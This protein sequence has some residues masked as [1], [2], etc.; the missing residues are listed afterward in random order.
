MVDLYIGSRSNSVMIVCGKSLEAK[1]VIW[2]T[3]LNA[4]NSLSS[5]MTEK[6]PK[7]QNSYLY[8]KYSILMSL[9]ESDKNSEKFPR[10]IASHIFPNVLNGLIEEN[11]SD[12]YSMT[13][14]VKNILLQNEVTCES[15]ENLRRED[16]HNVRI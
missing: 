12:L 8:E 4:V 3:I 13:K 7:D 15:I 6:K 10:I 1:S 9:N 14:M 2:K 5:C 16:I 11:N